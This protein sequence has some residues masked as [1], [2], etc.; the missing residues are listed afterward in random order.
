MARIVAGGECRDTY[1]EGG[2]IEM[3][4]TKYILEVSKCADTH[5]IT[6]AGLVGKLL[7]SYITKVIIFS[8]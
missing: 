8:S 2:E 5:P 4:C 3:S 1:S 7:Y 6:L